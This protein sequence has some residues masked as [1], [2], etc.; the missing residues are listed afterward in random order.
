MSRKGC[1]PV[2]INGRRT[3]GSLIVLIGTFLG[4]LQFVWWYGAMNYEFLR[5][6]ETINMYFFSFLPSRNI[7][8]TECRFA[9]VV[10]P[11]DLHLES[12]QQISKLSGFKSACN[13][14]CFDD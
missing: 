13:M 14:G 11:A 7:D 8:L 3:S 6:Y 9:V 10:N 5:T 2:V 4:F 12:E 1:Q